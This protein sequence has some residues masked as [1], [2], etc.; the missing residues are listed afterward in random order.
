MRTVTRIRIAIWQHSMT[1]N[2]RVTSAVA[3]MRFY[4]DG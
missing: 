3:P 1:D 2:N 4:T